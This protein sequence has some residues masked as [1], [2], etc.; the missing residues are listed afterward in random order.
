MSQFR[1]ELRVIPKTAW[2]LAVIVYLCSATAI[3]LFAIPSD[4]Q[5]R[6]WPFLGRFAFAYGLML[7]VGIMILLVGYVNGDA[8]RRGM[9]YVLWTLLAIF[10]PNALGIILYFVLRDP[11]L[12]ACPS[13]HAQAK[14]GFVFCPNCGASLHPTCPHCG[15]ATELGWSH[16]PNCGKNLAATTS[17]AT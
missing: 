10:I 17:S 13:C 14:G 3:F 15:K 4:P 1:D 11:L 5:L 7:L 2:F 9:R 8:K 16:C 6:E 12:S